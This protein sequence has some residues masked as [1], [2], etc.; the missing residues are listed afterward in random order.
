MRIEISRVL[1]LNFAA[2][3]VVV[4]AL[5]TG[6]IAQAGDEN[7]ADDGGNKARNQDVDAPPDGKATKGQA[8]KND[9]SNNA[10]TAAFKLPTGAVLSKQ[11]RAAYDRLKSDNEDDLRQAFAAMKDAKTT[12]ERNKAQQDIRAV[13]TTI[14]TG[15]NNIL[16]T[17]QASNAKNGNS[18][19][20]N[21]QNG[22]GNAGNSPSFGSPDYG[23]DQ[24]NSGYYPG[25]GGY[26]GYY[27]YGYGAYP[28][29]YGTNKGAMN[30]GTMYKGTMNK[31]TMNKPAGAAAASRPATGG[32]S[33]R[34]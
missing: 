33:V 30:K 25:Y 10:V 20:G 3:I 1:M 2:A 18:Q 24:P 16:S 21:S 12:A 14:R 22:N 32:T 13:K 17:G 9:A 7:D 28:Y 34:R 29:N 19:N 27:P 23:S 4:V 15:I 26:G 31:G 8:T 11:Q 5:A 6:N